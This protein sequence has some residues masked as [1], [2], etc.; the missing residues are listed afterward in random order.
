MASDVYSVN[1][2]LI[3]GI[4]GQDGSYM[5]ELLLEKGYRVVGTTRSV[6]GPMPR[7]QHLLSSIQLLEVD[8][9]DASSVL[10]ALQSAAPDE[11]YNFAAMSSSSQL[12]E[13]SEKLME[14][15]GLAVI[16]WLDAIIRVNPTI[17]FCQAS[18]SEMFGSTEQSP[19]R[20]TTCFRPRN[21]YG[22]AK[23]CAHWS[24]GLYRQI[25]GV[26]ACSCILFNHESPRR[27]QEY[28]TRKI[29]MGVANIIAGK[30]HVLKLGNLEARRDWGFAGDYVRAMWMAARCD[31][32]NDYVLA[33]GETHSVRDFCECAFRRVG[34]NYSDYVVLEDGVGRRADA[35]LLVGDAKLARGELLWDT[36]VS[37]EELVHMMVEA[38]VRL[39]GRE[40][41]LV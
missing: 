28:V 37:F 12:F 24:V 33:T 4:S 11:V 36:S 34:L 8:P 10:S 25:H 2:A 38:D 41:A 20:E 6:A 39:V 9:M 14:Y 19:Q 7:I 1:A 5:A 13:S 23:L 22:V 32:A 29:T 17:R 3:T 21:P 30:Q 16:R 26:H 15:N 27:G 40:D 35:G 18:S 31:R